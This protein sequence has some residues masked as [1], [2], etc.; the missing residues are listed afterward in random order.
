MAQPA[1]LYGYSAEQLAAW[2][3]KFNDKLNVHINKSRTLMEPSKARTIKALLKDWDTLDRKAKN[4]MSGG[5]ADYWHKTYILNA[6]DDSL[7]T[8]GSSNKRVVT[9]VARGCIL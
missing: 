9:T 1:Q 2:R 7:V 3:P 8:L 5:N 6:A 4:Q